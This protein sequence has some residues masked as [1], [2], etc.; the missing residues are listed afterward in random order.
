[1]QEEDSIILWLTLIL[2]VSLILGTVTF[3]SVS[4]VLQ[5]TLFFFSLSLFRNRN[6]S[7]NGSKNIALLLIWIRLVSSSSLVEKVD[8]RYGVYSGLISQ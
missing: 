5:F 4:P 6:V 1:M 8:V 3:P 2:L 7:E